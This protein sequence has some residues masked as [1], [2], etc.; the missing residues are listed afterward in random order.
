MR[1]CPKDL[2]LNCWM[3]DKRTPATDTWFVYSFTRLT[4]GGAEEESYNKHKCGWYRICRPCRS[5]QFAEIRKLR[6]HKLDWFDELD[7]GYFV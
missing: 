3:N 7:E 2:C 6:T 5:R 4:E 1:R